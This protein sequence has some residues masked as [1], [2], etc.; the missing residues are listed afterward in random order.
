MIDDKFARHRAGIGHA[1]ECRFQSV[2]TAVRSRDANRTGLVAGNRHIDFARRH[3]GCA[4]RRRAAGRV[5]ELDRI[6]N[7]AAGCGMAPAGKGQKFTH[8][9]AGNF[10]AR[11]EDAVDDGCVERRHMGQKVSTVV[12][13]QAGNGD[14]I[15]DRDPLAGEFAGNVAFDGR[16]DEPRAAPVFLR[17]RP[18]E[19][20]RH[21]IWCRQIFLERVD[22]VIGVCQ[23]G[24]VARVHFRF[25]R[26][27][28]QSEP[29]R[30]CGDAFGR[31]RLVACHGCGA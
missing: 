10:A 13:G 31:R 17:S 14:R 3:Q 23:F 11:G 16:R 8:S 24:A 25:F 21:W 15:L 12:H 6:F 20:A 7:V 4:A 1:A 30:G 18:H 27:Q 5:A 26:R 22:A 2:Q 19:C 28:R 29:L 9:L